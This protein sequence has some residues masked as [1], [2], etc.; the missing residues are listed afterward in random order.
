MH[1]ERLIEGTKM[2]SCCGPI[3]EN[4]HRYCGMG[5][6]IMLVLA[7][8]I[9]LA[10]KTGWFNPELFWPVLF[11][12]AGSTVIVLSL[13]RRRVFWTNHSQNLRKEEP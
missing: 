11:L 3:V 1:A 13:A 4:G 12:V 8:A 9:W 2:Y 6:G 5:F 7:G 10:V